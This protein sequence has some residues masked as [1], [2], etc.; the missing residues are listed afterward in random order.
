M[1]NFFSAQTGEAE[2]P[3]YNVVVVEFK[4]EIPA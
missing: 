1:K 4:K 3:A 2:K